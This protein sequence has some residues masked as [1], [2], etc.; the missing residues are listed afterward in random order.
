ME[1][2]AEALAIAALLAPWAILSAFLPMPEIALAFALLCALAML[3]LAAG[4]WSRLR[5]HELGLD[6]EAWAVAGV[7]SLGFSMLMLLGS[8]AGSGFDALCHQCGRLSDA[9]AAF[10]HGCGSFA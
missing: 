10:C 6:E 9:R 7:L 1:S 3:L 8:R 4:R 2:Q 5:A